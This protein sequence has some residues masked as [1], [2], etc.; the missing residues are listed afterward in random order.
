MQL[1]ILSY[2][3]RTMSIESTPSSA[4]IFSLH[5]LPNIE[6]FQC[7]SLSQPL[8]IDIHEHYEKKTYRNRCRILSAQKVLDLSI[9]VIHSGNKQVMKEVKIDNQQRWAK[10]HW[11]AM[12][13][14]YGKAPFFLYFSEELKKIYEQTCP[15]LVDFN[16]KLLSFCLDILQWH[17]DIKFSEKY[18]DEP[19]PE[20]DLRQLLHPKIE[21]GLDRLFGTPS[22]I[23][24]FGK[25]F[26]RNL[27]II[28][29][30]F[31]EGPNASLKIKE[32]IKAARVTSNAKNVLS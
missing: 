12:A 20:K 31:C 25:G 8:I 23:Q 13:S 4:F 19:N 27:S 1:T 26:V 17:P 32:T 22:Y 24:V 7:V 3:F 29:L 14:A 18:I 11:H 28:D 6:Y 10:V 2:I 15:Y 21:S 5:Y 9:P 30:I 16:L